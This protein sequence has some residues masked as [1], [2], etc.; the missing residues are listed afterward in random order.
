MNNEN[1]QQMNQANLLFFGKISAGFSH[2]INN[3]I[4]IIGEL[5]GLISDLLMAA[6]QGRP[7]D[8]SKL[9]EKNQKII[10]SVKRGEVLIKKFNKFAHS[11]DEP[12]KNVELNDLIGNLVS[13]AQRPASLKGCELNVQSENDG[14]ITLDCNP[15][16]LMNAV[17]IVI[18]QF[19]NSPEKGGEIKV[20]LDEEGNKV[21]IR[22]ESGRD[23]AMTESP[24]QAQ[25]LEELLGQLNA[26]MEVERTS[27]GGKRV[28]LSLPE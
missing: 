10:N 8:F 15:F 16:L 23:A 25:L 4:S 11:A 18:G 21:Q 9:R 6:E 20:Y 28:V 12:V 3:V 2:E 7:V 13:L 19:L 27:E 24:E 14:Q 22:I 17:F 1:L 26:E 5:A